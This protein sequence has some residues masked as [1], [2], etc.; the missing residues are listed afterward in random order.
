MIDDGLALFLILIAL[1][2][3]SFMRPKRAQCPPNE[4]VE[5]VRRDGST[6]CARDDSPPQDC[7]GAR[8]CHPTGEWTYTRP[9]QIYCTGGSVPIVVDSRTI[10]C[11][12]RH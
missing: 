7:R 10:G 12:A 5:G 6:R 11:Q 3:G 8:A 9:L 2:V 1:A 4:F